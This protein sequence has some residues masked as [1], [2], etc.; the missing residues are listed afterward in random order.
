MSLST[1]YRKTSELNHPVVLGVGIDL[2]FGVQFAVFLSR[3]KDLG[4]V[5]RCMAHGLLYHLFFHAVAPHLGSRQIIGVAAQHYVSTT[6]GHVGG[7]GDCVDLARLRYD[8]RFLLMVLGVQNL[9]LYAFCDQ[10]I[11]DSLRVR[12]ADGTD[13]NG[14]ARGMYRLNFVGDSVELAQLRREHDIVLV[15]PDHGNIR[16]YLYYV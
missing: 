4:I 1:Y 2:V 5:C 13:Q 10:K 14:S 11:G 3:G 16:R 8:L 15:L 7:Y 9:M 12:Y 6:A